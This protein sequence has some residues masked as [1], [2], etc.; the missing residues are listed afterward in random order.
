MGCSAMTTCGYISWE[1]SSVAA[2]ALTTVSL[3]ILRKLACQ[4]A[5]LSVCLLLPNPSSL[6]FCVGTMLTDVCY[7]IFTITEDNRL[8]AVHVRCNL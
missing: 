7:L 5:R 4:S 8:G 3:V 1:L 2:V 6:G